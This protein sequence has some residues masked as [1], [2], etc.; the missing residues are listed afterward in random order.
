MD[1]FWLST[2]KQILQMPEGERN[3]MLE[4]RSIEE[5]ATLETVMATL[6]RSTAQ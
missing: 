6:L 3:K 1:D 5:R 2:A 4:G